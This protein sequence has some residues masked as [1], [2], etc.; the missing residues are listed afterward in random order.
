MLVVSVDK[1]PA[2]FAMHSEEMI[3]MFWFYCEE[4]GVE[5]K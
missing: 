1:A 5:L 2:D 4:C 3:G